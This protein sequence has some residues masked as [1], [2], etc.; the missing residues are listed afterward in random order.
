MLGSMSG[1]SVRAGF[2]KSTASALGFSELTFGDTTVMVSEASQ[3]EDA[4]SLAL[5]SISTN[6][7]RIYNL[8]NDVLDTRLS[9][10]STSSLPG[11][12]N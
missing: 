3:E 6:V 10:L 9:S 5:L 7:D 12:F 8:L 11:G 4:S 2:G 1:Y